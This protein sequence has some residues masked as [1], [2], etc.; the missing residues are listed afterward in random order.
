MPFRYGDPEDDFK[1]RD[2]KEARWLKSRPV[3]DY[4]HE[5]IQDEYLYD[6]N[7]EFICEYCLDQFFR[8]ETEDFVE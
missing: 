6:I 1:L 2:A 7:G 4:C 5:P 3:C 8:K